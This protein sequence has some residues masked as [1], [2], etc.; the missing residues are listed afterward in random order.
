MTA[1]TRAFENKNY[2]GR[3]TFKSGTIRWVDVDKDE[4]NK[5]LEEKGF[6]EKHIPLKQEKIKIEKKKK[7]SRKKKAISKATYDGNEMLF[8]SYSLV[9]ESSP[10]YQMKGQGY[11]A[12]VNASSKTTAKKMYEKL[13]I[14]Y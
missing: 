11:S 9:N 6:L 2:L 7:V 8:F 10:I 5:A 14:T 4:V 12:D 3:K 13:E 1:R